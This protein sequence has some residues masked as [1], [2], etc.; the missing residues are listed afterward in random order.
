MNLYGPVKYG[1][2]TIQSYL[3]TKASTEPQ[4]ADDGFSISKYETTIE[5]EFIVA[6]D[7]NFVD[8]NGVN[9]IDSTMDQIKQIL[10]T[11]G[12]QLQ[13]SYVGF[14]VFIPQDVTFGPHPKVVSWEPLGANKAARVRWQVKVYTTNCELPPASSVL[15]PFQFKILSLVEETS[16]D[17]DDEGAVVLTTSGKIE[18]APTTLLTRQSL[19]AFA[20]QFQITNLKNFTRRVKLNLRNDNRTLEYSITDTENPSDNPFFPYMVKSEIDHEV[21]SELLGSDPFSGMGFTTWLNEMNGDFTVAP[22]KW[23][24]WAWIAFCTA[25]NQRRA[26]ATAWLGG[27]D[28]FAKDEKDQDTPETG[29]LKKINPKQITLS[30]RIKEQIHGRGV[31][32][33]VKWVTY[34]SLNQLFKATGM[35]Y[36]V[37]NSFIGIPINFPPLNPMLHTPNSIGDQWEL[38]KN[39]VSGFQNFF[40]YR[41]ISLPNFDLIFSCS[42]NAAT[43]KDNRNNNYYG[44]TLVEPFRPGTKSDT[45]NNVE[46]ENS[47]IGLPQLPSESADPVIPTD[48][49]TSLYMQGLTPEI[50]WVY[51]KPRFTIYENANAIKLPTIETSSLEK[52]QSNLSAQ[53]QSQKTATGYKILGNQL[54]LQDQTPYANDLL[55]VRG[56]PQ[57]YVRMYGSAIRLGWPAIPPVL[58]AANGRACYR[59]GV[60]RW[61]TELLNI[62]DTIPVYRAMWDT[63]YAVSGTPISENTQF[64]SSGSPAEFV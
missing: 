20:A 10:M 13:Y 28:G 7:P 44:G 57:Y 54:E 1:A 60:S 56:N 49:V 26:R 33:G 41:A 30:V 47:P 62:S 50:S 45:S 52:L 18:V 9:S 12:L 6:V 27:V 17:F 55:Q 24:G 19:R 8:V 48:N 63:Y 11:R 36:P 21:S 46:R 16:V 40:G 32:I 43:V 22:G 23:K 5:I 51:N 38:W 37:D 53:S 3:Q 31:N 2:L 59:I 29:P 15:T 42:D 34:T 25:L 14:G 61:E 64:T 4:L 58:V 35:F 39:T